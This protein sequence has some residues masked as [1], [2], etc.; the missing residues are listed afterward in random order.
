MLSPGNIN[1]PG[2]AEQHIIFH[3][4]IEEQVDHR[5]LLFPMWFML[6]NQEQINI[7]IFII[8]AS[9]FGAEE[10]DLLHRELLGRG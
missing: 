3:P 6:R 5:P 10:D 4:D 8:I 7:R 1:L 9:G 2:S